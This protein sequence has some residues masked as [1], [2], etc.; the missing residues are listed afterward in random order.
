MTQSE[1]ASFL[2]IKNSSYQR[3][4]SGT[5]G[6][7]EENWLKLFNLFNREIPLNDLMV[8]IPKEKRKFVKCPK[9][10]TIREK[11]FPY[12][13]TCEGLKDGDFIAGIEKLPP[14]AIVEDIS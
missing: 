10:D 2:N 5:R 7:T 11:E 12:C 13:V 8:S 9:C 14:D 1:I 6:T 4:E 3:I